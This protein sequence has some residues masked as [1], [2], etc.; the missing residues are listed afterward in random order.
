[1]DPFLNSRFMHSNDTSTKTRRQP[2]REGIVPRV[3]LARERLLRRAGGA[4]EDRQQQ[5]SRAAL[6]ERSDLGN[7]RSRMGMS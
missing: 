4:A 5:R 1:M 2:G 7:L 6:S 3:R